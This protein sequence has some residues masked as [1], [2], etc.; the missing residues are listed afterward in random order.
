MALLFFIINGMEDPRFERSYLERLSSGELVKLADSYGID[1]PP[2][3]DRIFIIKELLELGYGERVHPRGEAVFLREQDLLELAPL[4][5]HYNVTFI[6][7]LLRDPLWA[8]AFWGIKSH[9]KEAYEKAGDFGGYFLKVIPLA[10]DKS[11]P[12]P[13]DDPFII[14]VGT[15]DSSWYIAFPPSGGRFKAGFCLTR[16][17][18]EVLLALSLPFR[19]PVFFNLPEGEY[20]KNLKN[21]LLCLSG[22]DDFPVL[23]NTDRLSRIPRRV[24]P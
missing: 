5:K 24:R 16:G 18:G 6:D 10:N 22:L 12:P 20:E 4:P 17:G 23:R 19:I 13:E 15:G 7:V 2:G 11:G 21:P 14:P 9:D 8:F 3:L 1:I